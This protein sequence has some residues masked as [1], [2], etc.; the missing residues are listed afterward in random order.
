MTSSCR[1]NAGRYLRSRFAGA[2]GI[3]QLLEAF[4]AQCPDITLVAAALDQLA[5]FHDYYRQPRQATK[6][7]A[8]AAALRKCIKRDDDRRSRR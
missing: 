4:V 5:G 8:E 6:Y 2:D 3:L 1:D 7:R